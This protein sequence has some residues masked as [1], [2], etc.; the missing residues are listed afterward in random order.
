MQEH[1][2]QSGFDTNFYANH[3]FE[4]YKVFIDL[5]NF[6]SLFSKRIRFS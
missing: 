1:I 4:T 2:T 6:M 5:Q 3:N